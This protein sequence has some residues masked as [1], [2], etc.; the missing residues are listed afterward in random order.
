ML[1]RVDG[2]RTIGQIAESVALA[3]QEVFYLLIH[4]ETLGA[5]DLHLEEAS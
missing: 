5:V 3:P 4:L 1:D 2:V